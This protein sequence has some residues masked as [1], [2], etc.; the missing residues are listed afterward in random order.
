MNQYTIK[1]AHALSP[2]PFT[3]FVFSVFIYVSL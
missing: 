2:I 1:F 3:L